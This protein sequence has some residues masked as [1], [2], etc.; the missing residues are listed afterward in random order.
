MKTKRVTRRKFIASTSAG[1]AGALLTTSMPVFGSAD[2]AATE[3][4]LNGGKPVRTAEWL[5]WPVWDPE[6]EKPMMEILRSA[7]WYRGDG[8]KCKEFE[9]EYAQLIGAKRVVATASGSAAL[10]ASLHVAGVDAGDEVIVSPYTFIASYNVIFDRHALP[11]FADTDQETFSINPH[12]IE[13]KI[14]DRTSALLPVHIFGLPVDMNRILAIGKKHNLPVIE[15]ACQAWLAEYDGKMCGTLGDLG[16]FSFQNSKHIPSGEG[17]AISGNNDAL[18]DRAFAYHD[19]GRPRG[20][21]MAGMKENPIRGSNR[22]L[23]EVQAGLLLSMMGRARSDADKRLENALYLDARLKEIPGIVP[24][25]LSDGATRSSYHLYPFRYKKEQFDGLSRQKFMAAL[26]AEG[27]P[28]YPGYGKQ[29]FDGL[30]EEA[31][32]SRGYKRLF[33]P[34][35]LKRYR[36]E[37]HHLPGNDQLTEEQGETPEGT[38]GDT[39]GYRPAFIGSEE[40]GT[41]NKFA[42]AGQEIRQDESGTT[43]TQAALRE[44]RADLLLFGILRI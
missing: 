5:S 6:Y 7:D 32:S 23:T 37:L 15:D 44:I 22:R 12:K 29:Y 18:M 2:G 11:V 33:S 20:K 3:L 21:S 19:C 26:R 8:N 43:G 16:C 41:R 30:I 31:I 9:K 40:G 28:N 42:G 25:K 14:T 1:A 39:V 4:A 10:I 34:E 24:Y 38:G 13:E 35:R 36:E 27:I 17:G